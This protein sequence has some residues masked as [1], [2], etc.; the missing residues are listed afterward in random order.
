MFYFTSGSLKEL[1][2]RGS[3]FAKAAMTS[4]ISNALIRPKD[5]R[6][7]V[8]IDDIIEKLDDEDNKMVALKL[9]D[10]DSELLSLLD[11][12]LWYILDKDKE[13]GLKKGSVITVNSYT[14]VNFK[15][16]KE[17]VTH[18]LKIV[19]LSL[20]GFQPDNDDDKD[21]INSLVRS[22]STQLVIQE[23]CSHSIKDLAPKLSNTQWSIKVKVTN[24]SPIRE[25]TNRQNGNHGRT[26]RL[27]LRDHSGQI[28]MVVF[29]DQC[30]RFDQVQ[31][32]S[33]FLI[34]YGEIK[35][36]KA[37]CRAWP[38]ELSV[39][40]DIVATKNT[41]CEPCQEPIL[42]AP[43]EKAVHQKDDLTLQSNSCKINQKFTPLNELI[44]KPANSFVD[45][46][47]VIEEVG[48]MRSISKK[49]KTT[50][51]RNFKIVDATNSIVNVAVWGDEAQTFNKAKGC[52]MV[53]NNVQLTNYG[54]ISL[55]VMR[56]SKMIEMQ[57][58]EN[59][60]RIIKELNDWYIHKWTNTQK[61]QDDN[62]ENND[63]SSH[64][65]KRIRLSS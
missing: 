38:N 13:N 52:I 46:I 20:I 2:D 58:N 29:N 61:F 19:D 17:N 14:F 62:A 60:L 24:K 3:Q 11:K 54:D 4:T 49:N 12:S 65:S 15:L 44:L 48:E 9:N 5:P 50:P 21:K 22:T 63:E 26:M 28:E 64:D 57:V 32:N 27:Q 41:S 51:L 33:C 59:C 8:Y 30:D 18:V 31:L 40:Y 36:S 1:Y 6:P 23:P 39:I 42:C 43:I 56:A 53:L 45:V 25:F 10:T 34:K 7:L 16:D 37:S 35:Y 55:S 47:G